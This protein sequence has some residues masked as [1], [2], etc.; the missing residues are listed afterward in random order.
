MPS[1]WTCEIGIIY[2]IKRK[3]KVIAGEVFVEVVLQVSVVTS[4][5]KKNKITVLHEEN[6]MYQFPC[7]S[8]LIIL[9]TQNRC[10]DHGTHTNLKLISSINFQI[11]L[12]KF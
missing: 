9:Q 7:L 8:N 11:G 10:Y 1:N 3:V 2:S 5:I 4:M 12:P 6:S